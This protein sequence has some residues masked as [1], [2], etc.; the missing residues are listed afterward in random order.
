MNSHTTVTRQTDGAWLARSAVLVYG[1]IAYS[2][3]LG[4]ILYAIG[5]VGN[6]VVPK[7]I[8]SGA[9]S[10]LGASLL[11]NTALLSLFVLQHTVMARPAFKRWWMPIVPTSIERSTF[12]LVTCAILALLFTHWRPLPGVVWSVTHPSASAALTALSFVGWGIV[13]ASSFMVSHFDLFGLRQTWFRFTDRA[14]VP[15]GFRLVGLYR[16]VRHPLMLGFLI[17]FWSTPTMTVGHLFFAGMV[18][19]YIRFG[20][21]MEERD[22]VA[23]HGEHYRAY[24][25]GVS[26]IV[27]LP[28]FRRRA[29]GAVESA[30]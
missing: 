19:M 20:T 13:L 18:T 23:E 9:A 17:A 6:F 27:P 22:L 4:T 29:I 28:R 12:V 26:Y 30:R 10:P 24:R 21:W 14:Y 15:V 2:A 1:V 8:D 25:R 5:F 3:F 16:V 11:V 7:S